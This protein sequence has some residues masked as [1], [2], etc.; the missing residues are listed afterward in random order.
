MIHN[1]TKGDLMI[2]C[3]VAARAR[4]F[5]AALTGWEKTALR[6]ATLYVRKGGI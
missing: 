6:S 3:A 5:Y 4:T 1:L 2:D